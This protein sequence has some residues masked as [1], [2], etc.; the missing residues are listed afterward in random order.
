MGGAGKDEGGGDFFAVLTNEDFICLLPT[1]I[2]K[3]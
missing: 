3:G 1:G 2:L